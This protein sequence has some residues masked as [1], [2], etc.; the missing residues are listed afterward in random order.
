MKGIEIYGNAKERGGVVSFNVGDLH[1]HDVASMLDEDCIAVRSGH[2]C[3]QPLMERLGISSAA[4]ASFYIYNDEED[5]GKLSGSL[6]K[7]MKFT[8]VRV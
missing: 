7:I 2:H 4:R 5:I 6:K 1:S 3:A 8:E